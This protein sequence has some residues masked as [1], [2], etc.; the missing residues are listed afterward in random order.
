MFSDKRCIVYV[1]FANIS[2]TIHTPYVSQYQSSSTLHMSQNST[3]HK[4]YKML[5]H[6]IN[7][8]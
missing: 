8:L 3:A 6:A 1:Y 7:L 2:N 5:S 4:K